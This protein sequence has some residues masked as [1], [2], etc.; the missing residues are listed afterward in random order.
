[1]KYDIYFHNDFD[2][3]ASAA[4]VLAF[5]RDRGDDIEHFVPV[6]YDII[7]QW[8]DENFFAKH[9]LFKGKRNPAIIVDFPYHPKAAL[10]FDHHIKPFRKK[11]WEEKFK[12]SPGR[13]YDD[14]YPSACHL[15]Y[16]SL[17]RDFGWKPAAHLKELVKWL[18]VIDFAKYRSAKQTIEMKEPA[19]QASNFVELNTGGLEKSVWVVKYLSEKSLA[20]FVAEAKVKKIM[21]QIRRDTQGS[22]KFWKQHLALIGRVGVIDLTESR[23]GGAAHFAPYYLYPKLLYVVRFHPFPQKPNLFHVNVSSNAWR[24]AENKK[25]IGELLKK[26]GG[27][28]HKGV[29]G[30]EIQG[31]RETLAAAADFIAFLNKK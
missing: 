13:R 7:P 17:K 23:F 31:R 20:K 8:I 18:D 12:T 25:N 26:Y 11:G 30:V 24:R 4:V 10:W 6:K 1:M 5:L 19:L 3:H 14:T 16:D 21:R 9:K 27:G 15:A 2:G 29:G 28:G 22:L